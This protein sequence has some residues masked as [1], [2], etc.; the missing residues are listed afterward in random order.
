MHIGFKESDEMKMWSENIQVCIDYRHWERI[1]MAM[2]GPE[3]IL[4][5]R[6]K[7]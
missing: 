2:G 5:D 1:F 7:S 3:K 4:E 6:K